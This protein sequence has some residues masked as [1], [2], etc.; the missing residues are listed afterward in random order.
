MPPKAKKKL[1]L[2]EQLDLIEPTFRDSLN[3]ANLEAL[4]A[5][6]AEVKKDEEANQTAK[7]ADED[8]KNKKDAV[9]AASVGYKDLTKRNKLKTKYLIR[10]LSDSGDVVAQQIV[11]NTLAAEALKS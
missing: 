5:K 7:A 6:Y 11:M 1:T 9:E 2:E 3:G 4:R 8:L 10:L